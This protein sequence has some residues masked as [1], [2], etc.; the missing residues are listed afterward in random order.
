[1]HTMANVPE[2][3]DEEFEMRNGECVQGVGV[4]EAQVGMIKRQL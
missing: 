1:M 2:R 4:W 3:A